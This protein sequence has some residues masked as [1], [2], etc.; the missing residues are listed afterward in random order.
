MSDRGGGRAAPSGKRVTFSLPGVMSNPR[1][2]RASL[3]AEKG[4]DL[5]G[6]V[7][8]RV[9]TG[10]PRKSDPAELPEEQ[11]NW[12]AK[13]GSCALG[14]SRPPDESKSTTAVPPIS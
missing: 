6:P 11:G 9:P 3:R 5:T 8:N 1:S 10:A 13:W 7:S 12:D 2:L 4:T 14:M